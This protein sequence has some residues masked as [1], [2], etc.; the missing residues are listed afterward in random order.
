MPTDAELRQ[1]YSVVPFSV[2]IAAAGTATEVEIQM[3]VNPE[4]G[5]GTLIRQVRFSLETIPT[6]TI[7]AADTVDE[8]VLA[9]ALS[10]IQGVVGLPATSDGRTLASSRYM[11]QTASQTGDGG[12]AW[13]MI[14]LHPL[15]DFGPSGLLSIDQTL[16]VYTLASGSTVSGTGQY[17]GQIHYQ[18]VKLSAS[19]ALSIAAR[20]LSA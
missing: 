6:F 2:G 8:P 14:L 1:P 17:R 10:Q 12:V 7:P 9:I 19:E 5:I 3:P 11:G 16:S 13:N 18:I 20:Q 15:W 4:G